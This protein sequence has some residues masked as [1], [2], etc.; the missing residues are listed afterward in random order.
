LIYKAHNVGEKV[1]E[2]EATCIS[3]IVLF[4]LV[5]LYSSFTYSVSY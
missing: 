2:S 5:V 3:R 4:W 1:A